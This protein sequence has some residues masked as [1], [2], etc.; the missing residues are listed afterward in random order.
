MI[1]GE[2]QKSAG[3]QNLRYC[4]HCVGYGRRSRHLL[5]RLP[6]EAAL[7]SRRL[8]G[9]MPA[10]AWSCPRSGPDHCSLTA[11]K[12]TSH[13]LPE[14]IAEQTILGRERPVK[15]LG[16]FKFLNKLYAQICLK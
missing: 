15:K 7:L 8:I 11:E 1:A 2:E 5:R 16:D 10:S 3:R 6:P 14:G 9:I 13:T 4:K 12:M